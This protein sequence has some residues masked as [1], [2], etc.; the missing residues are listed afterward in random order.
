[1]SSRIIKMTQLYV[2]LNKLGLA[3]QI[4]KWK[5]GEFTF[6]H[7]NKPMT[8]LIPSITV[9]D[10]EIYHIHYSR[11]MM[12]LIYKNVNAVILNDLD[13]SHKFVRDKTNGKK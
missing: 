4:F 10:G 3:D 1:M 8:N 9:K 11:D 5:E 13:E 6:Y 7:W 12:P 2:Y